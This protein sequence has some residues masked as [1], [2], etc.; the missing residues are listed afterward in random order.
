MLWMRLC[1]HRVNLFYNVL[2]CLDFCRDAEHVHSLWHQSVLNG[3][4]APG[5]GVVFPRVQRVNQWSRHLLSVPR[6]S[7]YNRYTDRNHGVQELITYRG[8]LNW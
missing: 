5:L 3:V 1:P 7:N 8:S 6:N 4:L 2:E